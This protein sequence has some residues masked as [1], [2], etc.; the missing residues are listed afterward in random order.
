MIWTALITINKAVVSRRDGAVRM[1]IPNG[2]MMVPAA[3]L[4]LPIRT[5]PLYA[6]SRSSIAILL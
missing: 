5:R 3:M 4:L 6:I 1:V 2:A